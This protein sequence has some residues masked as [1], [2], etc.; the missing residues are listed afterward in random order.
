V[1]DVGVFLDYKHIHKNKFIVLG[2]HRFLQ[3]NMIVHEQQI[4]SFT[5]GE[6]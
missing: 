2:T 1:A 3:G 6:E 5:K 4:S